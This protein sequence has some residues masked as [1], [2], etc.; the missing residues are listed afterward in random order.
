VTVPRTFGA[1]ELAAADLAALAR[2]AADSF[3][4][5]ACALLEGA[6][7][8]SVVRVARVH[9]AVNVAEDRRRGFEVDPRLLV[10]LHRELRDTPHDI[11]G[12]WHSHPDG[13]AAPSATDFARAYDPTLAWVI[14]GVGKSGATRARAYRV[15]AHSFAEVSLT[16]RRS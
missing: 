2:A 1:V 5:E 10:R 11:V 4:D 7:S 14:T 13:S 12:V 6:R 9:V 8:G 15:D 3:P 16:E